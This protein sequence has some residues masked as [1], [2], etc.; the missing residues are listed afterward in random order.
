MDYVLTLHG[1]ACKVE[2]FNLEE[3][4]A[5]LETHGANRVLLL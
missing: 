1:G 2:I 5:S 3:I 4:S